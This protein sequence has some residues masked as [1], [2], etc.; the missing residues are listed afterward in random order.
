MQ[1]YEEIARLQK[2][3]KTA[4]LV[5]VIRV[6]GSAPRQAGSK[7]LVEEDSTIHGT[8]GGGA[9]EALVIKE[10]LAAMHSAKTQIIQHDLYDKNRVDTGMV[11]GGKMEFFIEPLS[12]AERMIIF[13]AGHIAFYLA[14]MADLMEFDYMVIDD[15]PEFCNKERFPKALAL[16]V[17]PA[18]QALKNFKTTSSD[19]M[20]IITRDHNTDYAI[21]RHILNKKTRYVGLIGSKAKRKEIYA[22][23]TADHGFSEKD[24]ERIHSPIGLKIGAETPQEIA[25]SIM[26]E[27]IKELHGSNDARGLDSTT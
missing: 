9:V 10:A 25:L 7:M 8:I 26:A 6:S 17:Q 3:R 2:Q 20:I 27:V 14:R 12:A 19:F 5:T 1:L 22:K 15:R 16:V 24:L 13:G 18:P 21:L 23:L 11:C 4:A